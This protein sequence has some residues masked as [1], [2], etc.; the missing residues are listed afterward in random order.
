[1]KKDAY[2]IAH[3]PDEDNEERKEAG[4]CRVFDVREDERMLG[5]I[6]R[7]YIVTRANNTADEFQAR[8]FLTEREIDLPDNIVVPTKQ[9]GDKMTWRIYGDE[10][11]HISKVEAIYTK[12]EDNGDGTP[13]TNVKYLTTYREQGKRKETCVYESEIIR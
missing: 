5:T 4:T 6:A 1:M 3:T 8:V 11:K 12:V 9:I 10:H 7:G 2:D 13:L